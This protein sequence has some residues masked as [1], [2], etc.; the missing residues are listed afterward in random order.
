MPAEKPRCGCGAPTP[1][2]PTCY[3]PIRQRRSGLPGE[4]DPDKLRII[5]LEARCAELERQRRGLQNLA[6]AR[7]AL[8]DE[9][10]CTIRELRKDLRAALF[11]NLRGLF[12]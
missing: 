2:V 11:D 6:K 5:Y 4:I 12:K 1:C 10:Y 9:A 3:R 7:S 8:L